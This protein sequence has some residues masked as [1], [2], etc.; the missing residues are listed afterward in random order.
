LPPVRRE[1][2]VEA[3][4]VGRAAGLR[5]LLDGGDQV[6]TD[7]DGEELLGLDSWRNIAGFG[8]L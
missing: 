4:V 1:S 6:R 8:Y 3:D 5:E 7:V 2:Q